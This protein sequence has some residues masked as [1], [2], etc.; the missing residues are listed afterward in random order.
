MAQSVITE[1]MRKLIGV[2]SEPAIYEVEK[3]PIRRFAM[4]IGDPNP[5]YLD[6]EYAK[7]SKHGAMICPAGFFGWPAKTQAPGPRFA[8][9]YS[10]VVNGGNE[11]EFLKPIKAGD[12]LAATIRITDMMERT[13]RLG[14]MLIVMSEVTYKN[15]Q[16]E[17]VAKSRN[18]MI[19]Y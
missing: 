7:K 14:P 5:L 4:A 6:E 1:E 18:T 3:G 16:G 17:V 10:R 8:G 2:E 11:F 19:N 9:P 12:V 13:G 15:Q